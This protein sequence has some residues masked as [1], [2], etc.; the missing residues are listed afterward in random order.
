M[1]VF[2]NLIILMQV[3]DVHLSAILYRMRLTKVRRESKDAVRV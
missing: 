1:L 3:F 2:L